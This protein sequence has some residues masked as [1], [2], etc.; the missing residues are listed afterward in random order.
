MA[1]LVVVTPALAGL[2]HELSASWTTIGRADG[3][4]F[5]IVETS[6]SNRHCEVKLRGDELV[7]RDLRSTNGTYVR[8]ERITEAVLK[9]GQVLRVGVIEMRLELSATPGGKA[10]PLPVAPA[11]SPA[12]GPGKKHQVL[13]VDDSMAFLEMFGG[14]CGALSGNTWDIHA[15]PTADNALAILQQTEIELVVLDL[16]MPMLDGIQLL[17]IIKRRYPDIKIVV[18]TGSPTEAN[19]TASLANGAEL[20]LEKPL[21]PDGIKAIFNMLNDLILWTHQKGFSGTL[22]QVGLQEVLQMECVGRHSSILEVRNPLAQG[23]IFI[24]VGSIVHATV[25]TLT[26]EAA[27]HKLLSLGGGEFRVQPFQAPPERT[28]QGRWEVLLMEAAR[29][30][31]EQTAAGAPKTAPSEADTEFIIMGEEIVQVA[32]YD[33][34]WHPVEIPK[35]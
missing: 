15:A 16:G 27:L 34:Q 35:K 7:V 10:P 3:N 18:L 12:A 31:D 26:G 5:Q 6:I 2:S 13:F 25:G 21:T 14:V 19:R 23:R 29:V 22:R 11:K 8:G 24:E 33:G 30:H 28:I 32:T 17:G 9:P 4:S 1:K 20:F